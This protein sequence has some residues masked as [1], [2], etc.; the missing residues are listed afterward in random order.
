MLFRGDPSRG[1]APD[2]S[3]VSV[4][5]GSAAIAP[6]GVGGNLT[7]HCA[8]TINGHAADVDLRDVGSGESRAGFIVTAAYQDDGRSLRFRGTAR[9]H[10]RSLELLRAAYS[11]RID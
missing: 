10:A 9:T 5:R 2:G 8:T 3:E 7:S 4:T 6:H 11:V 1:L